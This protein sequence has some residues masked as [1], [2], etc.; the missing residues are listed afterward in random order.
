VPAEVAVSDDE[1]GPETDRQSRDFVQSLS[2]GLDVIQA[3]SVDTPVLSL[4]GVCEKTGLTRATARRFL[5]TLVGMSY[6][7]TDGRL[8]WLTPRV[9][10]LGY[11]YLSGFAAPDIA[12]PH[13]EHLAAEIEESCEM[14]VLEETDV[15]YV[16]RVVG[17]RILTVSTTVG[18]RQPAHLTALGRVLL[19]G[20][21]NKELD[22]YLLKFE[23]LDDHPGKMNADALRQELERVQLDGWSI[24]DQELEQGLR[25]VAAPVRDIGGRVIVAVGMPTHAARSSMDSIREDLVPQLLTA[26][27]RIETDLHLSGLQGQSR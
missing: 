19:A 18:S 5:L 22:Q 6:V 11:A 17:P 14:A 16:L 27:K 20:L 24:V 12:L 1:D 10:E 2:R 21:P 9:L 8:F 7:S 23:K 4:S 25:T 26:V 15:V 3:F 13:L